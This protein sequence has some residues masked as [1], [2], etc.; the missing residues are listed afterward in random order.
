VPLGKAPKKLDREALA[1]YAANLLG[2]RSMSRAELRK[3]LALRAA[4]PEDV[5]ALL[6]QFA[7]YGAVDDERFAQGFAQSRQQNRLHGPERVLR[8]LAGKQVAA[9][10]ARAAVSAVFGGQDETELIRDYLARRYRGKDL[11]TLLA[12][13]RQFASVFRR[14]RLA[15]YSSGNVLKV[16][17][18]YSR[19]ADEF[20]PAEE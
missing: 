20:E 6:E 12:E 13:E 18:S 1:H 3:K 17:K 14:L 19:L 15:G 2:Q 4:N 7:E 11:K 10:L 5:A 16:L 8:D 9:G